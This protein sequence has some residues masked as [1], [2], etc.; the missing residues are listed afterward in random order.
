MTALF[1][2]NYLGPFVLISLIF[3]L[4][5]N[6]KSEKEYKKYNLW[7]ITF[8]I[9]LFD[10]LL[11]LNFGFDFFREDFKELGFFK[12]M[13]IVIEVYAFSFA[14]Y[15]LYFIFLIGVKNAIKDVNDNKVKK[16][17]KR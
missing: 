6:I 10:L 12:I 3:L 5:F 4:V 17:F 16:R 7:I 1:S 8:V 2:S 15:L 11:L 13:L 14:V 9:L